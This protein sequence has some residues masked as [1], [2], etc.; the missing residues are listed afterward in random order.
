MSKFKHETEGSNPKFHGWYNMEPSPLL[1][2]PKANPTLSFSFVDLETLLK[3]I[4]Q[5]YGRL[6]YETDA[7]EY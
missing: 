5:V 2:S 3:S 7:V 1:G 4:D 6:N